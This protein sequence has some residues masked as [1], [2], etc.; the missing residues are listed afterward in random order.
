KRLPA[1]AK[2]QSHWL[3]LLRAPDVAVRQLALEKVGDRDT[4]EVAEA[5]LEQLRH[6]DPALRQA[7]LTRLSQSKN[8]RQALTGALLGAENSDRAW[9]L[10]KAQ[11]PFAKDFPK[12]WREEVFAQAA[13]YVEA[14]DRR[15]DALLFLLREADA[16]DLR[17]R[18][19]E[20][21]VALR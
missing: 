14:N 5:L 21:A 15:A 2:S 6:P 9:A 11:V 18:L 12:D 16:T 8:G 20:R 10:A 19:E 1:D 7:A 4:D 3:N 13:E 17:D